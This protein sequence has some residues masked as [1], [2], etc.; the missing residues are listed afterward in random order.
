MYVLSH[1][2]TAG[3]LVILR[4]MWQQSFALRTLCPQEGSKSPKRRGKAHRCLSHRAL[5]MTLS[6]RPQPLFTFLGRG[7]GPGPAFLPWYLTWGPWRHCSAEM[8]SQPLPPGAD[9]VKKAQGQAKLSGQIGWWTLLFH[10]S[11]HVKQEWWYLHWIHTK[12]S[13]SS[14]CIKSWLCIC[15]LSG[16][17]ETAVNKA[18]KDFVLRK[19]TFYWEETVSSI[20]T[21]WVM[22]DRKNEGGG[23]GEWERGEC[24]CSNCPLWQAHMWTETLGSEKGKCRP[25]V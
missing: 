15:I 23:H 16:T 8:S 9:L 2:V 19:F 24:M 21:C 3:W 7:E 5:Q 11:H 20:L 13:S 14:S 1:S 6:T 22:T 25:N 18:D 4:R 10:R 17:E 12:S